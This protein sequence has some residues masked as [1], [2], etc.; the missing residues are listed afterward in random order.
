MNA[1]DIAA[2][3]VA[4]SQRH[5]P[6]TPR[7]LHMLL[8]YVQVRHVTERHFTPLPI[9]FAAWASGPV[10]V[11]LVPLLRGVDVVRL[12]H[13]ASADLDVPLPGFVKAVIAE[14]LDET[15]RLTD[16]MLQGW[17]DMKPWLRARVRAREAGWDDAALAGGC[18][19]GDHARVPW[20]TPEDFVG[21]E[22]EINP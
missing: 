6:M 18:A 13:L 12:E 3:V 15:R 19:D 10:A 4:Q 16:D 2:H 17:A 5:R 14:I 21:P 9:E 11:D 7:R 1:I 22:V 20:I 8:Y